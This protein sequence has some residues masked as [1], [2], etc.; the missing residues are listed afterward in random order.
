MTTK[1]LAQF[2]VFS[3]H[4]RSISIFPGK[5]FVFIWH[6]TLRLKNFSNCN[7]KNLTVSGTLISSLEA[8]GMQAG[9]TQ[10]LLLIL[11]LFLFNK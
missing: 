2:L 11:S 4:Q 1:H 9:E 6:W 3:K 8:A 7:V 5:S 10:V